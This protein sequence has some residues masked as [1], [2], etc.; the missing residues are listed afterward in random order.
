MPR[1]IAFY[2]ITARLL[3]RSSSAI[4]SCERSRRRGNADIIKVT[5]SHVSENTERT[6]AAAVAKDQRMTSIKA[7]ARET[8]D[9]GVVRKTAHP[10]GHR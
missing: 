8:R 6:D 7:H 5:R 1:T 9:I 2:R 3:K 4:A 10:G